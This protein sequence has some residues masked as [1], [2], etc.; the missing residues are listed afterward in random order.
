MRCPAVGKEKLN[1]LEGRS[2]RRLAPRP[3]ER[4]RIYEATRNLDADGRLGHTVGMTTAE[5][6]AQIDNRL[7][8]AHLVLLDLASGHPVPG[9]GPAVKA[10][11][12][13]LETA[14]EMLHSLA[15]GP[16]QN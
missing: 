4:H 6:I 9:D 7:A 10:A 16:G 2:Y 12:S 14:R 15:A 13:D 3:T 1:G 11:L 5:R 8:G